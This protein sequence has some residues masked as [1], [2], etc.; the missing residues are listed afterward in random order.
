MDKHPTPS[1]LHPIR[2]LGD[3]CLRTNCEPVEDFVDSDFLMAGRRL[4]FALQQFRAQ[5]GFGRA[6]AAPQIG[7]PRR[8]LAM[9]LGEG[10]FLVVNPEITWIS[11]SRFSMWDDCMSFPYLLVKVERAESLTL[12]WKDQSG[13]PTTWEKVDRPLSELIQ[14]EV[15]HLDGILAVDHALDRQSLLSREVYDGDRG[16]FDGEVDYVI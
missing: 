4:M 6:I 9:N 15:D 13:N 5:Y 1:Q 3:P 8:I 12:T 16:R 7:I 14:H 11:D 10:P 2:L